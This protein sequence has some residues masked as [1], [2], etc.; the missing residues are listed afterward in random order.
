MHT[1]T[2]FCDGKH[3]PREMVEAAIEL[4]CTTLGFSGHSPMGVAGAEEWTMRRERVLRYV[5]EINRLKDEYKDRI[6]IL[7][8]IEQDYFSGTRDPIFDYAIGSVHGIRIDGDYF[9]VDNTPEEFTRAVDKY[10]DG[11]VMGA[12]R[13]YYALVTDVVDKTKC[14]IIGHFDL[15]TKFNEKCDLFDTTSK[16]YRTIALEALDALIEKKKIFEINTGAISRGWRTK[17][18]PEDFLLKRLVEKGADL[19]I[20]SDSHHKDTIL[21]AYEDAIEYARSCGVKQLCVYKSSKIEKI[22]I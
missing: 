2:T 21:F 9:N 4:G 12:V 10:Y 14:D 11:N 17:P 16:E 5:D 3:T 6:E 1:H 19:M 7:A 22:S 8:G 13:D 18:Y 15:V 20:T